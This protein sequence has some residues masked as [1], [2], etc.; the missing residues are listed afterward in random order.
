[1]NV[2]ER[3]L[4]RAS[5]L[6]LPFSLLLLMTVAC[7]AGA[8]R[9]RFDPF[10]EATSDT[11][12]LAPDS[13]TI[14]IGEILRDEGVEL[15]HLRPREGYVESKWYDMSTGRTVSASSLNTHS[16]VRFRFWTDPTT[17]GTS[18]VVGEA[19]RRSRIDPSQPIR[20]TEQ[21]VPTD[22]PAAELV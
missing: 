14:R 10:P 12:P 6:T 9:P 17:E 5:C 13:A 22:H 19:A 15:E 2:S 8:A 21:P 3:A 4:R 16:V 18:T 1:M 20:L 11:F 7:G